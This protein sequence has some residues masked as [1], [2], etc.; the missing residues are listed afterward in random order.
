MRVK[1]LA[2]DIA[3][4]RRQMKAGTEKEEGHSL[5]DRDMEKIFNWTKAA[6]FLLSY[7]TEKKVVMREMLT[8]RLV[9]VQI[10]GSLVR[11]GEQHESPRV[12]SNFGSWPFGDSGRRLCRYG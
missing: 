4:P 6:C 5:S 8:F 10:Y 12:S 2:V 11:K 1:V 3:S 7:A 9:S